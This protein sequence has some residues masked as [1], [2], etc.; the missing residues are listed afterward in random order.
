MNRVPNSIHEMISEH[1][2]SVV[3]TVVLP[4]QISPSVHLEYM[5]N[6]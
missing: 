3:N 4:V 1:V 2:I 5:K 6:L